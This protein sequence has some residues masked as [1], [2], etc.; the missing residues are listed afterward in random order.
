[1]VGIGN[2]PGG[3][4][5]QAYAVS[6]D[7]SVV[8]GFGG[9]GSAPIAMRWIEATGMVALIDILRAVG[10]FEAEGWQ[11]R[12]AYGVSQDGKVIAGEGINPCGQLEGWIARIDGP[13]VHTCAADWNTDGRLDS[14]DFFD[15]LTAFFAGNA[16]FNHCAG[17]NSQDFF[18]F[19]AAFF[20]GCP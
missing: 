12:T 15:F 2:L 9:D 3:T 10:A 16:D 6:G 8:V 1:M 4:E 11:L 17:T 20:A 13:A 19:L 5:S 14:Q 7:G 18:D